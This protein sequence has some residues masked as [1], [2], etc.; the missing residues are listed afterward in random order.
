MTSKWSEYEAT[1][2]VR[3]TAIIREPDKRQHRELWRWVGFGAVLV[4]VILFSEW[5]NFELIRHGYRIEDLRKEHEKAESANRHLRLEI[6]TLTSP[7]R[8]ERFATE[9]LNL[10][11]PSQDQAIVLERVEVAPPPDTAI[12]ATRR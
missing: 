5:K 11:V 6:E 8:I 10:V 2:K 9:Q 12:V 1:P 3:N 7:K 4:V